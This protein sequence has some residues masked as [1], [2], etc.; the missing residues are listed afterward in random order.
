[1]SQQSLADAR[2][3][4]GEIPDS[5]DGVTR[6]TFL[7]VALVDPFHPDR[8]AVEIAD[9]APN[10]IGGLINHRAVIDFVHNSHYSNFA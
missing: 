3:T 5:A 10:P 9:N 8:I 1:M 2:V 6:F 7:D 4:T